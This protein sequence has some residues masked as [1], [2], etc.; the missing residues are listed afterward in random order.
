MAAAPQN[1]LDLG[2]RASRR[3]SRGLY[4]EFR[5]AIFLRVIERL[6]EGATRGFERLK[7]YSLDLVRRSM[8]GAAFDIPAREIHFQQQ[9]FNMIRDKGR[10]HSSPFSLNW[11]YNPEL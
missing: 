4:R 2:A 10:R 6:L 5:H 11:V 7:Q 1:V 8:G 9:G 3:D